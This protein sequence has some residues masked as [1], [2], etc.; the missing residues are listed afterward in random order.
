MCG[1]TG[2][3]SF[4][5]NIRSEQGVIRKMAE[6][7][8]KR[9]PDDTNVW[10][11]DHV[12]FGHKRLVVVDPECGKQPM[13]RMKDGNLYTIC[14]NGELYNTE[15]IRKVLLAKGYSFKGHSDTEVLLQ[16]YIEWE[17]E[18]VHHLNG[19]FAFAVWDTSK[20]KLFIGRDRLGVKPLFFKEENGS[21]IFGSISFGCFG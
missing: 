15:D 21:L 3:I 14:Y 1:I 13:T 19:I 11:E 18:C 16:S 17:E 2:W 5:G 20:E 12:L 4:K 7:L 10:G 8:A 6:T 9:G